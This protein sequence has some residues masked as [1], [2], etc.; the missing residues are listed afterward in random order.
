MAA[1]RR[2]YRCAFFAEYRLIINPA[3]YKRMSRM[4]MDENLKE[5][6]EFCLFKGRIVDRRKG[7]G[8][9]V[10]IVEQENTSPSRVAYKTVKEFERNTTEHIDGFIREAHN[11]VDFSGHYSIISPHF[12]KMHKGVPLV[13]MPYCDGDLR[14]LIK[15]KPDIIAVINIA[16]Q[17]VKG[18]M[19]AISRGM[20]YH[21]D[22]KP[23]NI[24]Y[25]DLSRSFHG[26]PP[27]HV[28]PSVRYSVKIADFGVANAWFNDYLGGTN[29]YKAPEQYMVDK[30]R[31]FAPDIFAVGIVIAELYQSYHPAVQSSDIDPGKKWKG[32]KLK[33]WAQGG[34]R[35]FAEPQSSTAKAL[36]ELLGEM[37]SADPNARPSF[38]R[39]YE[40]LAEMLKGLS[41]TT[42]EQMELLFDYYDCNANHKSLESGLHALLKLL[43]I[44]SK[45][46]FVREKLSNEL[47]LCL[48]KGLG[49][50]ENLF[51]VHFRANAL[52]KACMGKVE[53]V[54]RELL[55]EA[56]R[57]VV[58]F[59]LSSCELITCGDLWST[60]AFK[61]FNPSKLG[62]DLEAR[63]D[64]LFTSVDRLVSL[65]SYDQELR[66]QVESGGSQ[67]QAC[68][69]MNKALGE[70]VARRWSNARSLLGEAHL[71]ATPEPELDKLYK[72][73]QSM[74]KHWSE[75]GAKR[76]EKYFLNSSTE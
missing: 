31:S 1:L 37:L 68:I 71:L 29:A 66:R 73:W 32:S 8:G 2:Y 70:W 33:K 62:S 23:E 20:E 44:P 64:V 3:N 6:L 72:S 19:V 75:G 22:I 48:R 49:N 43:V 40:R 35:N 55:V 9:L 25:S 7:R 41:P 56:S 52:E 50:L 47:S 63:T 36:V 61:E 39:C 4:D 53:G 51:E 17:V 26:F 57:A 46:E 76:L 27:S 65:N 11:W 54:Q 16:L 38:A 28:D 24:L 14:G 13:C 5:Y 18:M 12:I 74:E 21:Q 30:A 60:P 59:V 34:V 42:L 45:R 58:L 69:L 67:I 15:L 10:Y